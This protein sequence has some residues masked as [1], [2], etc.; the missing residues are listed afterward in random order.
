M[1]VGDDIFE[2]VSTE[3]EY[4]N[5][6]NTHI[7]LSKHLQVIQPHYYTVVVSSYPSDTNTSTN[8]HTTAYRTYI[9]LTT[10][11][12]DRIPNINIFHV[13]F[14]SWST[15]RISPFFFCDVSLATSVNHC[16]P[17]LYTERWCR[18]LISSLIGLFNC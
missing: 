12:L 1:C 8:Y 11:K 5:R 15:L 17:L 16:L 10:K 3:E 6:K 9:Q 14:I 4:S 18:E 7:Y 13:Y 2:E